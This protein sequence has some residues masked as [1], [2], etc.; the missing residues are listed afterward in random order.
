MEENVEQQ[1][2]LNNTKMV[3]K[4]H[5]LWLSSYELKAGGWIA[6]ALVLLPSEEGNGERELQEEATFA[7]REE[8]DQQAFLMGK[9]WIDQKEAGRISDQEIGMR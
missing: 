7:T 5:T 6:R 9:Q 3:Y 1:I 4:N 8:A 2:E